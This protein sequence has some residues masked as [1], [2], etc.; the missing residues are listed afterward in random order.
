M[1]LNG[2]PA[3]DTIA[4]SVYGGESGERHRH[5][6]VPSARPLEVLPAQDVADADGTYTAGSDDEDDSVAITTASV[7]TA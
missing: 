7:T 4:L 1:T 5:R 3:A 2:G 6:L